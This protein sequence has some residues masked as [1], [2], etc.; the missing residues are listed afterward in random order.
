MF[1]PSVLQ[2]FLTTVL[3][4]RKNISQEH[5]VSCLFPSASFR[6]WTL[7][8]KSHCQPSFTRS[9]GVKD[10]DTGWSQPM[11]PNA[12]TPLSSAQPLSS[13]GFFHH[14]LL[15]TVHHPLSAFFLP[16]SALCSDR[17]KTLLLDDS[18]QDFLP[19]LGQQALGQCLGCWG[20]GKCCY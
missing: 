15:N 5:R 12:D 3:G 14:H 6:G 11:C 18:A 1:S 8:R 9:G 10:K 13:P 7:A 2:A 4:R 19:G 16:V 20:E 17:P